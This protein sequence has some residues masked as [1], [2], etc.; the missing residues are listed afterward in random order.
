[1]KRRRGFIGYVFSGVLIASCLLTQ[2][3]SAA[4]QQAAP[5]AGEASGD[6]VRTVWA[7]LKGNGFRVNSPDIPEWARKRWEGKQTGLMKI[8]VDTDPSEYRKAE[9]YLELWGG[10]PGVARKKFTLNGKNV[11]SL[12]EVGAEKKNCTYS[13]PSV[14]INPSDLQRGDNQLQFTCD[15]SGTFWG[16]YL[17][18]AAC[19]RLHLKKDH[20]VID[21]AGLKGFACTVTARPGAREKIELD[22]AIPPGFTDR[23]SRVEYMGYYRG[24]DENG[25]RLDTDWHGFTKDRKPIGIIASVSKAPFRVKWDLSMVPSQKKIAVRARVFFKNSPDL[26]Y[27]TPALSKLPMPKRNGNVTLCYSNN[28]PAPFWSRAVKEKKCTINI[29]I[30]PA[31]IEQARLH[32]VIWDGGK[33]QTAEP[34]TLNGHPM[35]VAG[36]GAHDVQ[37]RVLTIDPKIL[38]K[39]E[40]EIRL[41]SGTRHHGIEVLLPGPALVVRTIKS[42]VRRSG[43]TGSP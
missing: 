35:A 25:D 23:I 1:M 43:S 19:F 11:Y 16:H 42:N 8:H 15:G 30:D 28:L 3:C 38:R 14:S 9:L 34:F 33:G 40:N 7:G 41:L 32:V 4:S 13:Y 26:A 29:G 17:I 37:Y 24:Y 12:P 20:R 6:F 22:L 10:H 2:G 36:D 39:G 21:K 18:R 31:R 5:A 27:E